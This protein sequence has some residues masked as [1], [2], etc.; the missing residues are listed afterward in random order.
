MAFFI[1]LL[2]FVFKEI[3]LGFVVAL[4][5]KTQSDRHKDIAVIISSLY[6]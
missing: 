1:P 4:L 2:G 3:W 5:T 6:L